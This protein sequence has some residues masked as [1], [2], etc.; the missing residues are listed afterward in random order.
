MTMISK[1]GHRQSENI[2]TASKIAL[3]KVEDVKEK[4]KY[5]AVFNF[6]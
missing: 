4:Q 1:E 3:D 5:G 2:K 6:W